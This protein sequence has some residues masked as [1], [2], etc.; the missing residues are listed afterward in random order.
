MLLLQLLVLVAHGPPPRHHFIVHV[1]NR[2]KTVA[3]AGLSLD[4]LLRILLLLRLV[5]N[6]LV[7]VVLFP[8]DRVTRHAAVLGGAGTP[9]EAFAEGRAAHVVYY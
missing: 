9:V 3:L 2:I 6:L 5:L 4:F 1:N 8:R 7:V